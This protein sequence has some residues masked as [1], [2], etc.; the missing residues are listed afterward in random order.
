MYGIENFYSFLLAGIILNITPGQDTMYILGRSISQGRKA[1]VLSV[2]GI[3]TGSVIH[4]FAAALGLSAILMT[5]SLLFNI[6]KYLGALYLIYLGLKLLIKKENKFST[7]LSSDFNQ[8]G[9]SIYLQGMFTN[10]L[11][12]KIA[13]FFL[14]FLPQFINPSYIKNPFPFLILG[15]IFITSGTLWC[16]FIAVSSSLVTKTLRNNSKIQLIL[17]K[18]SGTLFIF[19]GVKLAFER[20]R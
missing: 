14:A 2:L 3:S 9:S 13:L 19:L 1:G 6:I 11:N 15:G 16:L 12:P 18:F 17:D 4:T 7:K 10:L 8:K 5:S 20:S